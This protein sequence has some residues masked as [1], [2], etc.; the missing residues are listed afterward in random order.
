MI[1]ASCRGHTSGRGRL[2]DWRERLEIA[3]AKLVRWKGQEYK[4]PAS[5]KP[6]AVVV[7]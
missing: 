2:V 5:V 6:P 3:Q 7:S 4:P 1:G